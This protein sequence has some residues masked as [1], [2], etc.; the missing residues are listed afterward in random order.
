MKHRFFVAVAGAAMLV[1][2]STN[3]QS[4]DEAQI[5]AAA[6]TRV[7]HRL[8]GMDRALMR[9]VAQ[10]RFNR[11]GNDFPA[12]PLA[13]LL[14]GWRSYIVLECG[15]IGGVT[16]AN[17]PS[18]GT[19]AATCE[20]R[21]YTARIEVLRKVTACLKHAREKERGD[22]ATCLEALTPLKADGDFDA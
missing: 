2:A 20:A 13:A 22:A 21:R 9:E 11:R 6:T 16:G 15:L 18:M 8:D 7:A 19:F 14:K 5:A 4:I 1:A 12:G 17:G 10:T 3:G